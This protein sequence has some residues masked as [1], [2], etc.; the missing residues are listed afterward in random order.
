IP[1]EEA[2]DEQRERALEQAKAICSA[3]HDQVLEAGG[4]MVIGT[5]RH[6]SRRIDNQLR[7]RSGRQG[8]PGETQF[9]LSLEDDLM[10]LF[11]GDRMDRISRM[12]ERTE[13][14]DDMPIQ[15]GMVSK[16]IENAQR[17]VE[18]MNFSTRK[19]V[20]EYD[21]VMNKQ[22][23]VIYA[24]RNRI[25]DGKDIHSKVQE[26]TV[27]TVRTEVSRYCS[28]HEAADDWDWDGLR[29]WF[30]ELTGNPDIDP[31]Q[32][33]HDEDVDT[34]VD[35]L[36]EKVEELYAQ[37]EEALGEEQVRKLEALVMLRV[38]DTRWMNHLQD[39]D[40]LKTG[41]GLR[42]LG[43]RDPLTEYKTEA[44]AAFGELVATMYEDYLRTIMRIQVAVPEQQ[45][46][47]LAGARFSGPASPDGDDGS[48]MKAPKLQRN[49]PATAAAGQRPQP[50]EMAKPTTYVK[51][52]DDPFANVG[53]NDLCPCG[54]G[55]KFKKCHGAGL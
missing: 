2:T 18:S 43:Q 23:E 27:D 10:R 46:S 50:G 42:A 30:K 4:L 49:A 31:Q 3:E 21:D 39:M 7:G 15:A 54:S 12:M 11:G 17:Q 35:V 55:K 41:I 13:M 20:L 38:I 14:P 48:R 29:A 24:E 22:R 53:R 19:H 6:E 40:Y 34:L 8:D 52:K 1:V 37:K 26:I 16:A 33:E 25:L 5:E 32:L 51:D 45:P 36:V 28:E 9:Y 47:N 44:H